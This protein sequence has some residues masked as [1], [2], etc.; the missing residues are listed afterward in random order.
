MGSGD[1]YSPSLGIHNI[2]APVGALQVD[3]HESTMSTQASDAQLCSILRRWMGCQGE[4]HPSPTENPMNPSQT[5]ISKEE[6]EKA[7]QVFECFEKKRFMES[8]NEQS[9]KIEEILKLDSEESR[10]RIVNW[11]HTEVTSS[12]SHG[13]ISSLPGLGGKVEGRMDCSACGG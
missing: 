1:R 12:C 5:N 9:N 3:G 8:S 6:E 7:R 10:K 11:K 13:S 2:S 4:V